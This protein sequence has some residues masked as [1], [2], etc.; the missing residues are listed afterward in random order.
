MTFCHLEL[1]YWISLKGITEENANAISARVKFHKN[2]FLIFHRNI[3]NNAH[4]FY[5][6]RERLG[7]C[8]EENKKGSPD[9][10]AIN[11]T[12]YKKVR[13]ETTNL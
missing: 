9:V 4:H 5:N 12:I 10:R 2:I 3:H 8:R 11:N 6:L 1:L 13:T 7:E